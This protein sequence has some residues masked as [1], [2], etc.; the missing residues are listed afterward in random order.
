M[1]NTEKPNLDKLKA[2]L[3]QFKEEVANKDVSDYESLEAKYLASLKR[4]SLVLDTLQS[5]SNVKKFMHL[6][7]GINNKV[8]NMSYQE[9]HTLADK[10]AERLVTKIQSSNSKISNVLYH[11]VVDLVAEDLL[12]RYGAMT[13]FQ[14][15]QDGNKKAGWYGYGGYWAY[16]SYYNY[17]RS[18]WYPYYSGISY[19]GQAAPENV[20]LS[21]DLDCNDQGKCTFTGYFTK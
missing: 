21:F 19:V 11:A 2:I 9:L 1:S 3:D 6:V 4:I 14:L 15:S 20:V 18:A 13:K 7:Q 17:Y 8:Q 10:I 16:P 12:L 5:D